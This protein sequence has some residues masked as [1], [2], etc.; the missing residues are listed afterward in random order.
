MQLYENNRY[1][2]NLLQI[3]KHKINQNNNVVKELGTKVSLENY[4]NNSYLEFMFRNDSIKSS[5]FGDKANFFM[6]NRNLISLMDLYEDLK[7]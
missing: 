7:N 2:I 4:R 1:Q 6:T 3:I 5:L